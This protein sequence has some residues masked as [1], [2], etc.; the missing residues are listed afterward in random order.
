MIAKKRCSGRF[1]ASRDSARFLNQFTTDNVDG[2]AD[3]AYDVRRVDFDV[4]AIDHH[5]NRMLES[6]P[7]VVRFVHVLVAELGG[8]A[9]DGLVEVLE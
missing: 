8:C 3:E 1:L 7:D 6:F 5:V 4:A 9:E 2:I